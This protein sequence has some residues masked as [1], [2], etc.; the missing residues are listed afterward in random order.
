MSKVKAIGKL[1]KKI[2]RVS[3]IQA[4][5]PKNAKPIKADNIT[6]THIIS[7]N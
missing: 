7:P 3:E 4:I 2:S 6:I 5:K 1:G